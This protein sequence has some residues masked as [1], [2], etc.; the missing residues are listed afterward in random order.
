ME[1][2]VEA[3]AP[4]RAVAISPLAQFGGF[5]IW[6]ENSWLRFESQPHYLLAVWSGQDA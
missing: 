4:G 3:Q 2:T 1:A 6:L 5:A